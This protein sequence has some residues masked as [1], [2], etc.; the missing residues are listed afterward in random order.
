MGE[1]A[2]VLVVWGPG[3]GGASL[4]W[5]PYDSPHCRS[6]ALQPA[7]GRCSPTGPRSAPTCW[8][9][10]VVVIIGVELVMVDVVVMKNYVFHNPLQQCIKNHYQLFLNIFCLKMAVKKARF[11]AL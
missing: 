6:K 9:G 8:G 5:S 1:A 3:S 7:G 11:E 10:V 2:A 4:M